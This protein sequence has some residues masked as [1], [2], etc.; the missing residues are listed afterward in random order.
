MICKR[1]LCLIILASSILFGQE[2]ELTGKVTSNNKAVVGAIVTLKSKQLADTTDAQGAFLI[3]V[4]SVNVLPVQFSQ[5]SIQLKNKSIN[6]KLDKPSKLSIDFF[7]IN[8]RCLK[9]FSSKK[10]LTNSYSLDIGN[11]LSTQ[12]MM[13]V[14]VTID[15]KST[16]F[17]Y[18]PLMNSFNV[19]SQTMQSKPALKKAQAAIDKLETVAPGY[20]TKSVEVASYEGNYDIELELEDNIKCTACQR[21]NANGSGSGPHKVVIETNSDKGINE[22]TI[23]H[24]EDMAPGKNYPLLV[25]G[26]GACTM[27][28]TDNIAAMS[29]IA[30]HGYIV[31]ADGRPGGSGG[32]S[33]EKNPILLKYVDWIIAENRKPCSIFYMSVDT[34]KV[35][36]NGFSCG[37]MLAMATAHDPRITTWGLSSSGSFGDDHDLWNSVHTPVLIEEGHQDG[38]GAYTNGKRDYNGISRLGHPIMFFSNKSAGHGGDLWAANGGDFTKIHLAWLNWWLKGD[39]GSTGKGA[40]VGNGCSWCSNNNWEVMSANIE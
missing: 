25:W 35:A 11:Q 16:S 31:V 8:G 3:K 40:L 23:Y 6:V 30:S 9:T 39:L 13:V 12:K 33:M 1:A 4:P 5:N 36:A 32:R 20:K 18:T 10:L 22:G 21:A 28:G 38:T 24:P 26:E 15:N 19:L 34:T 2:T 27:N 14:R 37:G 7:D 29:E 17:R